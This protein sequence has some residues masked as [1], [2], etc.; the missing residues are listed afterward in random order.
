MTDSPDL[1]DREF[2]EHEPLADAKRVVLKDSAGNN[3]G[4]VANPISVVNTSVSAKDVVYV[5]A[6]DTS[7]PG[8]FETDLAVYVVP[9]SKIFKFES[10]SGG[11]NFDGIFRLKIAGTV[12]H[13]ERNSQARRVFTNDQWKDSPLEVAAGVTI[14]VTVIHSSATDKIFHGSILGYLLDV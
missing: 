11:G 3:F 14:K 9:A 4:T 5:F 1:H 8:S 13:I 10:Y 12:Q 7:V 6:E 2:S